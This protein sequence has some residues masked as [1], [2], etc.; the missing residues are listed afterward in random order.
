MRALVIAALLLAANACASTPASAPAPSIDRPLST[1]NSGAN[2]EA[3]ADLSGDVLMLSFS[4]GGARAASFALGAL[5]GLREMRGADGRDLVQHVALVTSV[6]GGSILAAY[7]V[8]HGEAGIDTFRAAY[9]DKNWAA[10][11]HTNPYSP[12]NWAR[13]ARGSLNHEDRF[14]DWLD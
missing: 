11:L 2:A 6:S 5:Q 10:E 4:G 12:L 8:Q 3:P 1:A 13:A 14:A 7:F 9:L